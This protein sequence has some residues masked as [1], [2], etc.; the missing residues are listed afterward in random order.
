MNLAAIIAAL[1]SYVS[2]HPTGGAACILLP[3]NDKS[4]TRSDFRSIAQV[5]VRDNEVIIAMGEPIFT[6]SP[7]VRI[8]ASELLNQLVAFS[9][10]ST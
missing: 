6:T 8:S 3:A 5:E 1:Q 9:D 2:Q 10:W 4:I 7:N